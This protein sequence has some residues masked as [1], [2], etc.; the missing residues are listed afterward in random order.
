[1]S[2]IC[3]DFETYYDKDYSLSKLTTE[4][5]INDPRFEVIGMGVKVDDGPIKWY[6][7]A[8]EIEAVLERGHKEWQEHAILCHNTLFDGAIL[9]WKY[10]IIPG[11]YFD[12]L[13]MARALHGVEAGGSLKALASRYQLGEK[14]NEV[15]NALGK[16]ASDF[17]SADL[18]RYGE[19]CRNDVE[20]TYAL[21]Q[22]LQPFPDDELKLIDL[23]L[24]MY[25]DPVLKVDDALLVQRLVQVRAEKSELLKGLMASLQVETEE[26]VRK[27]LASNPKFAALL[28][29]M[30]VSVPMKV[31]KTTG[32]ETYALAKTDQ[33]FIEL[34]EH[35]NPLV[36]QLCAVRLG[37]KSTIEESRIERFIGIGKR[38]RGYLPV[39]LRYYGAHT[40]RW[41]GC[42]V[43]DSVVTVYNTQNGFEEKRLVDVLSDDL[44]WDGEAFVPHDGVAFSGYAEVIEWDGIRGTENHVV[45][46]DAGALSLR[47]AMQRGERIQIAPCPTEDD[48]D[49]ARKFICSY[50]AED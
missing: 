16:R 43:D 7:D 45:Y 25:T 13:S 38:N 39:P 9:A 35:D 15:V 28:N 37:T 46:T 14:G 6:S 1:M 40:G 20:L 36:Q 24:R 2:I 27:Q 48:V 33:G 18:H 21:F 26:E 34:S 4:E 3:L 47:E 31:S 19:Y 49:A 32:K 17:T 41:S 50:K 30:N 10:G 23:T 44:V 22:K 11:F 29:T 42:L 12:T 8:A 5:Y